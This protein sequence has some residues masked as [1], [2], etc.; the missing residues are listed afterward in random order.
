VLRLWRDQLSLALAPDRIVL[1]R[2]RGGWRHPVMAKAMLPVSGAEAGW[3][4]ALDTLSKTLA[5]DRQW[6]DA[7]TSV[8]LSN[9][10]VRYQLVP[11]SDEIGGAEERDAYVRQSF[12]QV[13]GDA[14]ADWVYAVSDV[15]RGAAWLAC[16]LERDLLMQLEACVTQAGS[17]LVSVAPHI[18]PAF[19][20]A[21]HLLKRKDCW[22]VQVEKDKLLLALIAGGHWKTLSSRQ[23]AGETWQH[24]LPLL[25]EREW[26]LHG[27]HQ[28]PREVVISAPEAHQAALD[29]EGK[30]V[31][32]WLRPV[33]RY[34]LSGRAEAPYAMA[35][36]A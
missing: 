14:A 29:G 6:Q 25:L 27:M 32:H 2:A 8:V 16:A 11:W 4:P 7:A 22:F 36:G 31:F 33:L 34:G 19:N 28:V 15:P 17:K 12:A 20:G 5:A 3:K 26:R 30:W 35:L 9:S 13:Y 18:M 24:E 10:F 1:V 21:R 23:I